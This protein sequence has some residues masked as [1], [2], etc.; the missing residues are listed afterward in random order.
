MNMANPVNRSSLSG[1][2]PRQQRF[3]RRDEALR[4]ASTLP[5]SEA[6]VQNT[7]DSGQTYFTLKPVTEH[8]VQHYGISQY[9]PNIVQFSIHRSD[10]P[11]STGAEQILRADALATRNALESALKQVVPPAVYTPTLLNQLSRDMGFKDF[12]AMYQ[13]LSKLPLEKQKQFIARLVSPEPWRKATSQIMAEVGNNPSNLATSLVKN[14]GE[15]T[16]ELR[17]GLNQFLESEIQGLFAGQGTPQ[18]DPPLDPQRPRWSPAALLGI[19]NS[20][21]TIRNEAPADFKRIQGAQQPFTFQLESDPSVSMDTG[22]EER[23]NIATQDPIA[24]LT[25][26]MK[27][28]HTSCKGCEKHTITIRDGAVKG[29]A[30]AIL[31]P[32]ILEKLSLFSRGNFDFQKLP[33]FADGTNQWYTLPEMQARGLVSGN[34]PAVDR[35]QALKLLEDLNKSGEPRDQIWRQ[36][37]SLGN[38]AGVFQPNLLS[39]EPLLQQ[40]LKPGTTGLDME[41]LWE[42]FFPHGNQTKIQSIKKALERVQ[43]QASNQVLVNTVFKMEQMNQVQGLQNFLND[44][45]P[46]MANNL[47][48]DGTIGPRTQMAIQR[49][50]GIVALNALKQNLP[51]PLTKRQN[52]S[53]QNIFSQL[54][55]QNFDERTL[56]TVRAR[57]KELLKD[58]PDR[59]VQESP[60]KTLHQVMSNLIDRIDGQFNQQTSKDL[61]NSWLSI[62]DSEGEGNIISDLVT[63]EIGHNLMEMFKGEHPSIQLERDWAAISGKADQ[64]TSGEFSMAPATQSY[65]NQAPEEVSDY[66]ESSPGEDFAESYRLFMSQPEELLKRAPTKF[67]VLNA[68]S[69]R[70][71]AE[72]IQQQFGAQH[73]DKLAEAWHKIQGGKEK[74]FHLSAPMLELLNRTYGSMGGGPQTAHTPLA[75]PQTP[76]LTTARMN[77]LRSLQNP[78]L[79]EAQLRAANQAVIRLIDHVQKGGQ[80][81]DTQGLKALLGAQY[82]S[83]PEGFRTQ[84]EDPQSFLRQYLSQPEHVGRSATPQWVQREALNQ[85]AAL[86]E[87]TNQSFSALTGQFS[88]TGESIGGS[89]NALILS[90]TRPT[91]SSFRRALESALTDLQIYLQNQSCLQPST[92]PLPDRATLEQQLK[93]LVTGASSSTDLLRKVLQNLGWPT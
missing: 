79:N 72:Q 48:K 54:S 49:M 36:L 20:L 46:G 14:T 43:A 52:Q 77:A 1:V 57:M 12:D 90:R 10:N 58:V 47:L 39:S 62:V 17:A 4:V 23:P 69:G 82:E 27:I 6:I 67:L 76:P 50:E 84:L 91:S 8:E 81:L 5:G 83:L 88:K 3:T 55:A 60:Q 61:I 11:R 25:D 28:A 33:G 21:Q 32:Q 74:Q 16:R 41:K 73:Q 22:R 92:L 19:H 66:G 51:Q 24:L 64:T 70:F 53:I 35:A 85:L 30:D 34:P 59:I 56:N 68:L 63:H 31:N 38:A 29:S 89:L 45:K 15:L 71:S 87:R 37:I 93:T 40:Y 86:Y 13:L 75:L 18:F 2:D 42:V 9:D 65:F 44:I 26:S 80:P 7:D 78:P